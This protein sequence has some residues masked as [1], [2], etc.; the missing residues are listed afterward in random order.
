MERS[1]AKPSAWRPL[2]LFAIG[3][4]T[5]V[6]TTLAVSSYHIAF[7]GTINAADWL[8]GAP[9]LTVV[10]LESLRLPLAFTLPRLRLGGM[11]MSTI[12]LAGLSVITAES[13]SIAFA[14]LIDQRSRPVMEA[15]AE[16]KKVDIGSD[17]LNEVSA[18]RQQ[19]IDR[20]TADVKAARDHAEE[21][22]KTPVVL[23]PVPGDRIEWRVVGTG[24]HAH[25][26][27]VNV[28]AGVQSKS[29][30]ADAAAQAAH[31]AELKAASDAV[32]E[33]EAKQTAAEANPAPDMHA[34]DE[35]VKLAKQKVADA[36]SMNPMFR[37]AAAWQGVE[38]ESLTLNQ[39]E[40]VKHWAVIALAG[41][42]AVTS[43]LA[44]VI[45]C[46]PE[47]GPKGDGKLARA[48][49][50]MIAARRKTLR[51]FSERVVTQF[52]D[53]TKVVYIPVDVAT[54]KVLD[55]AFQPA[56]TSTTSPNFKVVS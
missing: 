25:R 3:A 13:A 5:T 16:L 32:K 7:G 50:K 20:L 24:K 6:I 48:M 26:V 37:V 38:V 52:K 49:R 19:E 47:R 46:L 8:A 11:L 17:T 35:A 51:R 10:A 44:A 23:Q 53:R 21:I 28:N 4:E 36:R 40:Q 27:P 9:I 54:G 14:N 18:R 31:S 45:S 55:P 34:S 41:A 22:A 33:A 1:N 2:K 56:P 30:D 42:T 12:M 15:E 43:A 39:F 29:V